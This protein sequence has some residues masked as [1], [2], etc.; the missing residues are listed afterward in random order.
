MHVYRGMTAGMSDHFLVE[1][2][3][4]VAKEWGKY[5][6]PGRNA[7]G[8]SL[9]NMCAENEMVV[10]NSLFKKRATNKYTWVRVEKGRMIERAL[11]G[12]CIDNKEDDWETERCACLKGYD[13]SY[14]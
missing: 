5:G 10:G 4:V 13:C 8:E 7:S 14:V 11:M 12:L 2:K 9:L 1:G 6:V 3:M